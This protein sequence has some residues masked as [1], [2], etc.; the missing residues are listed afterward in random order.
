MHFKKYLHSENFEFPS[1]LTAENRFSE[2][3]KPCAVAFPSL[4]NN[5]FRF[6]VTGNG[7]NR[8]ESTLDLFPGNAGVPPAH[9]PPSVDT[10]N[11]HLHPDPFSL[12]FKSNKGGSLLESVPGKAF[13]V[14]GDS[15]LMG[16]KLDGDEKFYGLGEK[17]LGLELS[18]TC[19][20]FWNTD[21]MGDF[22]PAVFTEGRPDP[23]Y[24]SIPYLIIKTKSGWVGILVNNPG[25]VMVNTGAKI[26][27]EGLMSVGAVDKMLLIGADHGQPDLFFLFADSLP[28]LTRNYQKLVGTTPLPPVWS[29]GYHQCR[30]GYTSAA[31]LAGYKQRFA[32][33]KIPVD[34]LWLDIDYMRDY[35]VFTFHEDHFP[36]VEA[37]LADLQSD[38]QHV[39]PIIDPGVKIDP[40]WDVYADGLESDVYCKNPQGKTFVGQVWPGDTAFVDYARKT[41]KTW[42][43]EQVAELARKGIHGCWNDMNDPSLGFVDGTPMLW[44]N[45]KK[46][47]WTYH[48]QFAK[49]MAES[50]RDG[51]LKARPDE[52]PFILSRS[53]ST[54]M[55]RSAA[56]WH[57]DSTAN[58]HWLQLSIP[59]ALNLSLSGVPFNGPDL[60]GF[61]GDTPSQLF[62]DYIKACFLFPFCRNHTAI[63]TS[64]QEPW[65][66]GKKSLNTIRDYIQ[67]RYRLRPYLYQLFVQQEERGEAILRPLFYDFDQTEFLK[68][69][70]QFMTGPALLQAPLV[71]ESRSRK[72][73]LPPGR[74]WNF[75]TSKWTEGGRRFKLTPKDDTTPLYGRAG[76]AIPME[77]TSPETHHWRGNAFDLHLLLEPG[78][79][80]TLRGDLV[81]DDGATFGYQ[82]GERTRVSYT[83]KTDGDTLRITTRTL[84]DGYGPL[85]LN[86]VLYG[87]F[88]KVVVNRKEIKP[89]NYSYRLAG[90][91]Q[92][93]YRV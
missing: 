81:S 12:S 63:G 79:K 43:T 47:H 40:D 92:N 41:G 86:F 16:F 38:G 85:D 64:R 87:P 69:D 72:V 67:D 78:S 68:V 18:G 42:W 60:G 20:K 88:K 13:G 7:W 77:T 59:T 61:G 71:Q 55:A 75:M 31:E 51:F 58:Y 5:I 83:A 11:A 26:K 1:V 50:T 93:V 66:F 37:D 82:R 25:A 8:N 3:R 53:G 10:V 56:I 9:P 52:R 80:H 73:I 35:R 17:F 14:C 70:D 89:A 46:P 15:F 36:N 57:G 84:E 33:E 48:N 6:T 39:V 32:R 19:T 2:L 74:W 90:R 76:T 30:W 27:V 4:G 54:G 44:A 49:L 23:A 22:P 62:L 29:L 65:S 24:V 34:G 91:I 28:E 21:I 45:G